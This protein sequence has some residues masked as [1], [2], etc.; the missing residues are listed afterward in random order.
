MIELD[1]KKYL[2]ALH[3][4]LSLTYKRFFAIK[5]FFKNDFERAF[6]APLSEWQHVGIDR[7]GLENF[8]T[9]RNQID[10]DAEWRQLEACG[11]GVLIYDEPGYPL[12][13]LNIPQP[14]AILFIRGSLLDTD[15]PSVSI[16][17]SRKI[18]PYGKRALQFIIGDLLA[19][20]CTIVSGLAYGADALAHHAALEYGGRTI[21][22]LGNGIDEI[23]PR[24]NKGLGERILEQKQG[25]ILSEYLPGT[26]VRPE[27][28]P[29]RNRIV[30]GLSKATLVIEA[31]ERSGSL[32]TANLA[33]DMGREVFA[34]PGEI[35]NQTAKGA[36]QLILKGTAHP[37]LS[38]S[39]VAEYLS[40]ATKP[41]QKEAPL[42]LSEI[43]T[44]I[45][46]T[47]GK[48]KMHIDEIY[49]QCDLPNQTIS[50]QLILLEMKGLICNLGNQVYDTHYA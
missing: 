22:V 41:S 2:V 50:S 47:L 48:G 9:T 20:N 28:F 8:L 10:P 35:F 46:K 44:Q 17:G 12:P 11:A 42:N 21:A 15:F 19:A 29:V 4:G 6:H 33:N 7:S 3:R 31:A 25:A 24:Q 16:V 34:V 13:L 27:N 40:L 38:G 45:L 37:A 23:C 26:E 18:S 49:R 5:K 39:M 30:A 14:P 1:Q 43:E 32:I 36:N